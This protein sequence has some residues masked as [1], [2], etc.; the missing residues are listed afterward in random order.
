MFTLTCSDS[1]TLPVILQYMT[2]MVQ[3]GCWALFD[4]TDH[5]TKGDTSLLCWTV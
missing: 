4:D 3:S 2:G 5:L 1:V